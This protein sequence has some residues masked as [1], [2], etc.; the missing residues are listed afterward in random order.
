[1]ANLR[2]WQKE[3]KARETALDVLFLPR[4]KDLSSKI[5]TN[6]CNRIFGVS[7]SEFITVVGYCLPPLI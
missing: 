3:V 5:K 6:E 7:F 2:D 1:M 4:S